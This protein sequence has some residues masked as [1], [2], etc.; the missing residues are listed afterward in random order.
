MTCGIYKIE[1]LLNHKI[2]IGQS[3]HI[4]KRWREH[5]ELNAKGLIGKAISKY[6]KENFSFQILE[7]CEREF[8]LQKEEYYI[9]YYNSVVPRGYNI[10]SFSEGKS[11]YFNNYNEEIFKNIINDIKNNELTFQQ[12]AEKY[13]LSLSMIYYLNRGDYHTLDNETYPLRPVLKFCNHYYCPDCGKEIIRT[14]KRCKACKDLRQQKVE[15]PTREDLKSLIREKS[16]VQ[17]GK[18]YGVTDNAIR[19]W[20]KKYN[21]PSK[22]AI[23]KTYTDEEW[24]EI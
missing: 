4:E 10:Q 21:L 11:S 7:I 24:S 2:Y 5:C 3:V 12:I 6:G 18:D 20:C 17:I 23:I 13:D 9:R 14:S 8:L 22:R 16:F 19:K 15:R 1:N